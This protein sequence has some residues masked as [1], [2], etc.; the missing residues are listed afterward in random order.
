M[1]MMKVMDS[2]MPDLCVY[3]IIAGHETERMS[4]LVATVGRFSHQQM[5]D[6]I[7][8]KHRSVPWLRQLQQTSMIRCNRELNPGELGC[9]LSHRK[10]WKSFYNS[11]NSYALILESDAEILD[12]EM[13]CRILNDYRERFDILF[14]GSYHGRTKLRRS[15]TESLDGNR[16]I[17]TP[18]A[19]TL[20]CAYGYAIN[21][22]TAEYLLQQTIKVC[23]PV[24]F[25]KKWLMDE[26]HRYRIRVGA[27]VPEVISTWAA[28]STIQDMQVVQTAEKLPRRV[29]YLLG[30]IKNSIIGFFC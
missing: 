26:N 25:W 22:V 13:V 14:L 20:Y 11:T 21:K 8:P 4:R 30:E 12:E 27:V 29:K 24:D 16:R 10:A 9:L 28:S 7:F 2:R 15:T 6:A 18:L 5:V 23:W 3:S 1:I 17:G 19:N